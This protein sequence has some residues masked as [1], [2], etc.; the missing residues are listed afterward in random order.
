MRRFLLFV[1]IAATIS[2]WTRF[3]WGPAAVQAKVLEAA[4]TQAGIAATD[5]KV[6]KRK[7]GQSSWVPCQVGDILTTGDRVRTGEDSSATLLLADK[8]VLRMSQNT[9]IALVTLDSGEND[10]LIRRFQL[11]TGRMWADVTP[12]SPPGSVF[13]VQGPNA[14]AA[15]KGTAFEVGAEEGDETEIS[16]F[17][18]S[19]A[20]SN[21]GVNEQPQLIGEGHAFNQFRAG[22]KA[23]GRLA[24]LNPN[25]LN[26]W[27]RWNLE[28]RQQWLEARKKLPARL[29]LDRALLQDF[30]RRYHR[31]PPSFLQHVKTPHRPLRRQR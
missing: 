2:G 27:Q 16:V 29:R 31:R 10:S 28:R 12:G 7:Q 3:G 20:C 23:R 6:E 21:P 8:S 11:A 22:R 19:V 5:N 9:E 14:V 24:K 18:G 13:E 1:A 26:A 30:Q 17:E 15:V 4:S 25:Q